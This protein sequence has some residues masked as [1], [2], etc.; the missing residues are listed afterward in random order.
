MDHF[1]DGRRSSARDSYMAV[2]LCLVLGVPLFV[3]L[4]V[5]TAGTFLLV[6][7]AALVV[8]AFAGLNYLLWGRAFARA[9]AG[10][11]EEAQLLA[12]LE[13]EWPY[14]DEPPHTARRQ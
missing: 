6:A 8:C 5:V 2:V 1:R 14:D 12:E 10:E 3:F 13:A 7:L 4:N 11:R 9:T